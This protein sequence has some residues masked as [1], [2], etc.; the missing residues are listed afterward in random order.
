MRIFIGL[1]VLCI[2]LVG[3]QA[4]AQ[5]YELQFVAAGFES[6]VLVVAA[7][8][9]D[10][11]FVVQQTGLVTVIEN[12]KAHD[13]LDITAQV[14]HKGEA[15]LLGMALH[16][17]FL[18][19][20]LAYVS[21]T[22]GNLASVIEEYR[23][24]SATG[25]FDFDSARLIFSVE[26]PASNHNG[27]MVAFGPDGYLYASFG[28]GGRA[29]DVFG[30]GQNTNTPLGGIL[31]IAVEGNSVTAPLGNPF[32][33]GEAPLL[34]AYGLRNPWRFSFDEGLLYIGDAGQQTEEEVSVI[35]AGNAGS[36][37]NLGWPQAEG[38]Q[39]FNNPACHAEALVWPVA[40][41]PTADGCAITGGY[42]YRGS[43][44]P[45]LNGTYFYGDYC[46]GK[47]MSFRYADGS[48][49]ERR[50]WEDELTNVEWLSGFGLG[51]DGELYVVS[52][53]GT[54]YRLAQE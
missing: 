32:T 44:M 3:A 47:I 22:T 14:T 4:R 18:E 25:K 49:T 37:L 9:D 42:V 35:P 54:I 19:N 39:C 13:V 48:A 40:T 6:P 30:N 50:N 26:Q 36:G 52:L 46:T 51:G 11:L 17:A 43:A 5:S 38:L 23:F 31:R 24:D 10:R 29:N 28:D 41:Y 53:S 45:E 8:G 27:G 20:G 7:K 33:T 1:A 21:Y 16:P 15:G 12:Q 2:W 34:W